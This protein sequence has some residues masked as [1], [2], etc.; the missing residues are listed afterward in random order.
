MVKVLGRYSYL[1]SDGQKWNMWLLKCYLPP[2]TTLTE[3]MG[4]P[5][6]EG[7]WGNHGDNE[8]IFSGEEDV[9]EEGHHYLA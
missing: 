6:A 3:L 2:S 5:T 4:L 1:L 9:G 8:D 7:N